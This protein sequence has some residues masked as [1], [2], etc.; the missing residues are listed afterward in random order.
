ME[1]GRIVTERLVLEPLSQR[2]AQ[3]VL[4]GAEDGLR[5]GAGWPHA[6][7]LDALGMVAG[8]GSEAWLV[9]EDGLVIGDAGTH[10]PPDADGDVEIGYGL[11]EPSRGRGLA[12]EFVPAL[13]HALLARP[14][15]RRVVARE[16]LADNLPSRRALERAGFRLER[17]QDGLTWYALGPLQAPN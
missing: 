3:A 1:G 8:H 7:T 11:A 16:V 14:K 15:V 9:L 17:E 10:G 4:D 5:R 6:E 13:A 2:T 12:S